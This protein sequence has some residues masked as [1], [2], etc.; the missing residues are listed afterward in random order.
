MREVRLIAFN[1][2]AFAL[3]ASGFNLQLGRCKLSTSRTMSLSTVSKHET[4]EVKARGLSQIKSKGKNSEKS[5]FF[6]LEEVLKGFPG[7]FSP[8]IKEMISLFVEGDEVYVLRWKRDTI[9]KSLVVEDDY[10]NWISTRI[11]KVWKDLLSIDMDGR[12]PLEEPR[13]SLLVL[14]SLRSLT[15]PNVELTEIPDQ[16]AYTD[17]LLRIISQ[18]REQGGEMAKLMYDL[19]YRVEVKRGVKEYRPYGGI[20]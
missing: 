8:K 13:P 17:L 6:T 9:H 3:L 18:L 10:Q 15:K 16:Y 12:G 14:E 20:G 7:G 4:W 2:D 1:N 11:R 19:V 5:R